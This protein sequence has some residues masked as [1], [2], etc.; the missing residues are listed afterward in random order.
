MNQSKEDER[1]RFEYDFSGRL[2]LERL[3]LPTPSIGF[4]TDYADSNTNFAWIGWQ[5]SRQSSHS[6]P[7]ARLYVDSYSN[8]HVEVYGNVKDITADVFLAA[9]HQVS[10]SEP[11]AWRH[12]RFPAEIYGSLEDFAYDYA[13]TDE[14]EP[15]FLAAPHQVSQSEPVA[16][17]HK[18]FP[19]EIYGS[20]EDFAYDYAT[21]DEAEPL[22]LAAPQQAI[23]S[24]W[25]LVPIEPTKEM[26]DSGFEIDLEEETP[27]HYE[28]FLRQIY[29]GMLSA[30]PTAPIESDK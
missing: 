29:S 19:A 8:A 1:K 24:G 22:F 17:R 28:V 7:V 26:L 6:E 15:L 14:A 23:P 10:Q 16:W 12:K 21:T 2:K 27:E 18:R 30:S 9:P 4:D 25:K 5:A 11:V 20:L 13:T 3:N